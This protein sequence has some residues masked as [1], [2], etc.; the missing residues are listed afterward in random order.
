MAEHE[1]SNSIANALDQCISNGVTTVLHLAID[2]QG[3][4]T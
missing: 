1:T 2:T 3:K 4:S